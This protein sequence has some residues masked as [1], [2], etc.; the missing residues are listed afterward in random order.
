MKPEDMT[1][2]FGKSEVP[3][4]TGF[5]RGYRVWRISNMAGEDLRGACLRSTSQSE[6]A[7][8]PRTVETASCANMERFKVA[9][10][11][12]RE[13]Q[14]Y[15]LGARMRYPRF[16]TLDQREDLEAQFE[17]LEERLQRLYRSARDLKGHKTPSA[18]PPCA[19]CGLYAFHH[20]DRFVDNQGTLPTN[21]ETM[22]ELYLLG[23][24][25][26]TGTIIVGSKGIRAEKMEVEALTVAFRPGAEINRLRLEA[27]AQ[28]IHS[29]WYFGKQFGV[30]V[31]GDMD[32]LLRNHPPTPLDG[33]EDISGWR[34]Q[35][36][37]A[38]AAVEEDSPVPAVAIIADTAPSPA[39]V[40]TTVT[41]P[42]VS[43]RDVPAPKPG[44]HFLDGVAWITDLK[45]GRRTKVF[46]ATF[47]ISFR[48]DYSNGSQGD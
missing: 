44:R 20:P 26:A 14:Q 9:I 18:G 25:R 39:V 13:Q 16:I 37:K 29:L 1:E 23:S 31:Y 4:Y 40:A 27:Q 2:A 35:E 6:Y 7:W 5:L 17:H 21:F 46:G 41:S 48:E 42:A 38:L 43:P 34:P 19:G 3:L 47:N 11:Q 8:T 30:P 45:T 28:A 22:P 12:L 15:T 36:P 32:Q 24:V 10:R 33:I